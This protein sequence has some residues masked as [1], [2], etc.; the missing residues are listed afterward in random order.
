MEVGPP[1]AHAGP[2]KSLRHL[3]VGES[4]PV[5]ETGRYDRVSG[6]HCAQEAFAR[7]RA[8]AMVTE[9]EHVGP[10][11]FAPRLDHPRFGFRLRVAREENAV[12]AV[13]EHQD[14]RGVIDG[15]VPRPRLVGRQDFDGDR[16][17]LQRLPSSDAHWTSS[18]DRVEQRV[19]RLTLIAAPPDLADRNSFGEPRH[20]GDVVGVGV[21][22][23]EPVD[24]PKTALA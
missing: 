14:H 8:A 19:G 11:A 22:Q 24:A 6:R 16:S 20:I 13:G 1:D 23:H 4:E 2:P 7:R 17:D 3:S 12:V 21:R 5:V 18:P 9:L 15:G 10:Q